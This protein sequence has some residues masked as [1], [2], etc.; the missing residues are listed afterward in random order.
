MSMMNVKGIELEVQ[1][2]GPS[3][4]RS[5]PT[6]V[7]LHEG[8]GSVAMWDSKSGPWPQ[9]LCAALDCPG[10]VYS[11]QGYGL[12]AGI[13]DV[14]GIGRHGPDFMHRQAWQV[15]PEL[16]SQAGIENTVLVGHS[17]GGTI[18]LLHAARHA[19]AAC[20]VMAPH[21]K[22]E[23]MSIESI[24]AAQE[25]YLKGDLRA[26]LARFHRDVDVAFWQ[27][28]DVWLSPSFR[29]FDIRPICREIT[30][31]VLAL[32]GS[33]DI[34]G[35]LAQINEIEPQG[36]IERCVVPACGHSPHRDQRTMVTD[37]I[38]RFLRQ[39]LPALRD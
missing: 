6:V 19:V 17:D 24:E 1:R 39:H 13:E 15:L 32:Q 35:T 34:Y 27:W 21:V 31:P 37:V 30:T 11:R 5:R 26:R 9:A 16:L 20:V 4:Q 8:L 2:I 25:A 28:C 22:V 36:V 29:D 14:R 3:G 33:D 38:T 7:F 10:L 12:S 18:A 23:A